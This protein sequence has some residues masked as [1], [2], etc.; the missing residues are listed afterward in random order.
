[1]RY[2]V[3]TFRVRLEVCEQG[4]RTGSSQDVDRLARPIF[5]SQT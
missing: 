4:A 5:S 2:T 1:M 3:T